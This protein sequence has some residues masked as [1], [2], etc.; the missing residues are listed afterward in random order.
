MSFMIDIHFQPGGKS[1]N[2]RCA[3]AM[4][5]AGYLVSAAAELSA[6]MQYRKYHFHRRQTC[7]M[8]DAYGNTA[9][10]IGNGN[11]I[12]GIDM[13]FYGIAKTRQRFIHGIIHDLVDQMMKS[14]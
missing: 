5:T 8:I 9:A 11:G 10:V 14:S 13:Y 2:N 12:A 6:G 7:F 3:H 4:K 1:I